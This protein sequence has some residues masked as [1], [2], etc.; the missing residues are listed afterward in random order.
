MEERD[1]PLT[2]N[3]SWT[4]NVIFLVPQNEV[5][6]VFAASAM[7]LAAS[8]AAVAG[9]KPPPSATATASSAALFHDMVMC[10]SLNIMSLQARL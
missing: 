4:P 10:S 1:H 5:S 8:S 9:T 6:V 7:I 2:P 3:P